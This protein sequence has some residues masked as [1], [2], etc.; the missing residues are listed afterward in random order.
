MTIS[1][2][3]VFEVKAVHNLPEEIPSIDLLFMPL[4]KQITLTGAVLE[5]QYSVDENYLVFITENC[6]FEESLLISLIDAT[7][8]LL[9]T[10]ELSAWYTPG[11][12]S[13]L[14]IQPPNKIC[15]SFFDDSECWVLEILSKTITQF[16]ANKF[17]VKRN[18]PFLHKTY[19]KLK[20]IK[21]D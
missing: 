14:R 17:P 10:L 2:T 20:H 15:F 11:I 18:H 5:A 1:K 4:K 8:K 9:D 21:N 7:G 16:W 13:N 12:L 3:D 19:I 6:P